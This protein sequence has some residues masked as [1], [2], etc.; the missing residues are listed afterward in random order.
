MNQIS[1]QAEQT[2]IDLEGGFKLKA[3]LCEAGKPTIGAGH[4]RNVTLDMVATESQCRAWFDDDMRGKVSTINGSVKMPL[5]QN[6][7]D[8]L[9]IWQFNT[10]GLWVEKDGKLIPSAVLLALNAG[11]YMLAVER[12][13]D[14]K[15]ITVTVPNGK[16]VKRISSGLVHRRSREAA[17]FSTPVDS[18]SIEELNTAST[19]ITPPISTT[20]TTTGKATVAASGLS[21]VGLAQLLS[22]QVDAVKSLADPVKEM[23]GIT[24]SYPG[25]LGNLVVITLIAS[26]G[27][28]LYTLWHKRESIS[29]VK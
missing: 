17:I 20:Q 5:N 9:C 15:Y 19:P 8:A 1:S 16:K 29:G 25:L 2:C 10:G 28:N 23:L 26:L 4:T 3:Y 24:G 22:S 13:Q 18:V 21:F 12:M 6:Q 14:W 11:N 27:F 7:F